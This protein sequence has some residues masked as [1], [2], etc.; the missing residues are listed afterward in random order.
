M[1]LDCQN[2]LLVGAVTCGEMVVSLYVTRSP[3]Y[4]MRHSDIYNDCFSFSFA[5]LSVVINISLK[6]R[7]HGLLEQGKCEELDVG[8]II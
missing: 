7:H 1:D 4:R 5:G 3:V 6:R 8:T 2:N